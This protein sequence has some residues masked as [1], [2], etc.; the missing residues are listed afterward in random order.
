MCDKLYKKLFLTTA[1]KL[2]LSG[3]S[4]NFINFFAALFFSKSKKRTELLVF[5]DRLLNK[6]LCECQKLH[7]KCEYLKN[8]LKKR[9]PV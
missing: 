8:E 4:F 6:K 9:A 5:T 3:A 1:F 2:F 7:E